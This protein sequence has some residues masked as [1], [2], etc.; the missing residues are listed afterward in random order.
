SFTLFG[1]TRN[2]LSTIEVFIDGVYV[3]TAD[4]QYP[5]TEQTLAYHYTG[6][7]PGPHVARINN[8]TTMRVDAFQSNPAEAVPYQPT[9][10]WWD[11]TPAGNGLPFF[12]TVGIAAGM[13]AGDLDGDGRTE[14]ILTADDSTNFGTLFVFRGN[15]EDTGD[16]DPI[17]WS[18]DFGGGA[19][20]T[21]VGSPAI[22]ELD[23]QPGAEV[24][25]AAG[26]ELWA[27]HAD[28]STYWMT[29]T[30]SIFET[31]SAPA[32]G[33][34]DLDPEPEIVANVGDT[35]EVR[36]HDGTLLWSTTAPPHANPPVL[37]DLTG[38]GL[39]DLI[40]TGWDDDVWVY[41][42][43]Q[44][45]PQLVWTVVLTSSMAGTFGAPAVADIDGD[46]A[47]EVIV[48]HY[49]ALTVLNG[50]DGSLLWTTPLDPGNPGGVSVADLDGDGAVNILTG[51]RYEFESGRFGMIYALNPDGSVLWE[52]IAEDSSSAN[53]A[54]VLDLNG[55][56][57][58]EVAWNGQEQGFTIYNGADGDVLFNEPLANSATGTDYPL[59]VDVDEDGYAEVIVPTIRGVVLFG[60]D[61]V[62]GEARP[63][64]NQH[65]YHISNVNDDL[66]IPANEANSWE[67]HN[68]Y[69]TQWPQATAL[70]VY[71]VTLTH[72]VGISG[73]TVLTDTFS[74]PP[75]A[76]ADPDY[77][78]DYAQTWAQPV[79][80]HTFVSELADMQ[81]G[82]TRLVAQGT[83]V[84]YTLPSGSNAITLPP[85]YVS[86]P[87]IVAITPPSATAF[88]GATAVYTLTLSNSGA[89][90][91]VY[92]LTVGGPAANWLTLP[93]TVEVA[94]GGS[95]AVPV[96]AV[97]PADAAAETLP[98]IVD[99]V[100][101]N[102]QDA[103]S[104]ELV[105][106]DGLALAVSPA[107]QSGR[108]GLPL[109]YTLT[110]TNL[111]TAVQT[112]AL[113]VTGTASV[114]LPPSVIVP[115]GSAASIAFAA[116]PMSAGPQP[117]TVEAVGA[118]GAADSATGTAVGVGQF[119]VQ[120]ALLPDT[121][122]GGRGGV[123]TYTLA[124]SNVGTL[125]DS[126]ALAVTVPAGWTAV[127]QANGSPVNELALLAGAYNRA[128]LLLVVW[129][130][131]AA[132]VGDYGVSVTAVSQSAP[133]VMAEA[134]GTAQVLGGGV[135]LAFSGGPAEIDPGAAA[136]WSFTVTNTGSGADTFDLTPFGGLAA[137][138]ELSSTAVT[139]DAGQS[140]TV[141]LAVSQMAALPPGALSLGLL[142]RSQ[143]DERVVAVAETAVTMNELEAASMAWQPPS[144]TVTDTLQ[145]SFLLV[146]TNTGNV[147]TT[148][149]LSLAVDGGAAK[150]QRTQV[151]VPVGGA[152]VVPVTARVTGPGVYEVVATA[153]SPGG[154]TV[155]ATATLTVL[156][157]T[158]GGLIIYLPVVLR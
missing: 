155:M 3:D 54:S 11:N 119:G 137:F 4:F 56:G 113:A 156:S 96:T 60:Q 29:N 48:S 52:A 128:E 138:V 22:A 31:L 36:E 99:V 18:H 55:D 9:A 28:G 83:A 50:E 40:L 66:T 17:L 69:R 51:M 67:V 100:V 107:L 27:F 95:V 136:T 57:A 131:V 98:I 132:G 111:E 133:G 109:T 2:N 120:M 59:F 53:N 78:W 32:I 144:R 15:G 30:V 141:E 23:G 88:A 71:D 43:N 80:T 86:A 10:E 77:R 62:W 14:I 146:I 143:T 157:E 135:A 151:V 121:A 42:F 153:V 63:L 20:R 148:Y 110:L 25:V 87:H 122:A 89:A 90:T 37:A 118:S 149:E 76:S 116:T 47:P 92:T 70:P 102:V 85:L 123:L 115:G 46:G 126:Y 150:S 108:T 58:Y 33:N 26:S 1:V 152:A 103:A 8:G 7:E 97:I 91:A 127:L 93:A 5:Y 130:D 101:D 154:T 61:G 124:I 21:W 145:A 104:A 142:A 158:Q 24:V 13:T 16:G 38:D 74:T 81:P 73:V 134:A 139:L 147:L 129:P 64:W 68:T 79:M 44:G 75:D 105:V 84:S 49:G 106:A 34:L 72:T 6:L 117:F 41:D 45:A 65:S 12:G 112:Y 35:V 82:E 125:A 19:Y 39:L 94:A 114:D 140:Q